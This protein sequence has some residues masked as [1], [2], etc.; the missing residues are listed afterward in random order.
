MDI[1]RREFL[2]GTAWMG[3]A[4]VVAGCMS[5]KI[6][7]FGGG[8]SMPTH[9]AYRFVAFNVWGDFF[10]NPVFERDERQLAILKS[11][12]PDFIGLQEM[13]SNFWKSRMM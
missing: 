13:T 9:A 4:A 10:G 7:D 2:K 11:H 6:A 12:D 1:N 5:A 3:A 8:E